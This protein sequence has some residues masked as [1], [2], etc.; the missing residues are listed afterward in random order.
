MAENLPDR[1][2]DYLAEKAPD[3]ATMVEALWLKSIPLHD[4]QNRPDSNENGR[5]HVEKVE[6][7]IW[8]LLTETRDNGGIRNLEHVKPREVF[9]LSAAACCHDFDKA[10]KSGLPEPFVHGGGSAEFVE[11][12]AVALGID[13]H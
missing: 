6:S 11:R 12:N 10:L 2:R 8:R 9:L 7:N 5:L 3:L 4:R 1:L 13:E